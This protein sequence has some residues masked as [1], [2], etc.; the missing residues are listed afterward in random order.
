MQVQLLFVNGL[1]S[2]E[3]EPE[4]ATSFTLNPLIV[5]SRLELKKDSTSGA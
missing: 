4:A 1:L 2:T 5:A 3:V